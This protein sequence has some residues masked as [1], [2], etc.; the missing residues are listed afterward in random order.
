MCI[1]IYQHFCQGGHLFPFCPP[2][3]TPVISGCLSFSVNCSFSLSNTFICDALWK[4]PYLRFLQQCCRGFT[5]IFYK[6][7]FSLFRHSN[8]LNIVHFEGM[9][10]ACTHLPWSSTNETKLLPL[11]HFCVVTKYY[12]CFTWFSF[13]VN[14]CVEGRRATM[15]SC[16]LHS[17]I[18][19]SFLKMA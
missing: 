1:I 10:W 3:T 4:K 16:C 18:N 19:T 12:T 15:W 13:F 6:A 11:N 2:T 5:M 8:T 17:M 9:D 7:V 14:V